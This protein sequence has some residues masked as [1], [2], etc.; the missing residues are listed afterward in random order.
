[1]T[2]SQDGMTLS[3]LLSHHGDEEV[4]PGLSDFAVNVAVVGQETAEGHAV[5]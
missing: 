2:G 5:L 4:G 3:S 1:M